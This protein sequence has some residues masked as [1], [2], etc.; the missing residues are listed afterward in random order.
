MMFHF[1]EPGCLVKK[2]HPITGW[3]L[4]QVWSLMSSQMA[5]AA[6]SIASTLRE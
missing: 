3:L 4:C 2:S 5:A 6:F 1:R